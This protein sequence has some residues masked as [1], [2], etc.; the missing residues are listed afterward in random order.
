MAN[1]MEAVLLVT[2]L[3]KLSWTLTVTAGLMDV[4]AT[5]LV[6]CWLKANLF[7]AA[8]LTTILPLVPVMLLVTVSVAVT[9]WL[10]AVL[11][12]TPVVN[13]CTPLSPATKV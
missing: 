6:G 1:V 2:V 11:N 4:P 13:V 9:V 3:P 10:P 7:A 5:V 12:V 8:A